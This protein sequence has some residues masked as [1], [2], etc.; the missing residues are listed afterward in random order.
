MIDGGE[1]VIKGVPER[2]GGAAGLQDRED[3]DGRLRAS[4]PEVRR[5]TRLR[6]AFPIKTPRKTEP[7]RGPGAIPEVC[8]ERALTCTACGGVRLH[9][10]TYWPGARAC[11]GAQMFAKLLGSGR[12]WRTEEDSTLRKCSRTLIP[13]PACV[14]AH[15]RACVHTGALIGAMGGGEEAARSWSEQRRRSAK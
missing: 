3:P 2:T 10:N 11:V 14:R 13:A 1:A 8:G 12:I 15:V 4:S 9:L 5:Q 6:S 7:G